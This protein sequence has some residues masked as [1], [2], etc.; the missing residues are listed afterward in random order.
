M[1]IDDYRANER[2]FQI[3]TQVAGRAGREQEGRVIIQTYNPDSL[4]I[5]YSKKQDYELFY[6]TEIM[7]RK[8]LKYP[9]F[10]D[11]LMLGV[12]SESEEEVKSVSSILHSFF[13]RKIVE[14]N[15]K[16]LLYKP[17][18]CPIEKIKN[19]FRWRLII[20]CKFGEDIIKLVNEAIE[21]LHTINKKDTYKV[22]IDV[23][24]NNM[25]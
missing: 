12:S 6:N 7:I 1:N 16:I 10:C 5:E 3:L 23:N 4:A 9:P 17:I 13:K 8:G 15:A 24:P 19:K 14:E 11:I 25:L 21:N 2:T 22:I 18:P 20:K